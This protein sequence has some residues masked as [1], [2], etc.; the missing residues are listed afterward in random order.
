MKQYEMRQMSI[1]NKKIYTR[2]TN[3]RNLNHKNENYPISI[4]T[5]SVSFKTQKL[6]HKDMI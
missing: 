2:I 5:S 4:K 6:T 1:N 3:V